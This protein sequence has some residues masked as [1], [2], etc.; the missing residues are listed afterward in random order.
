MTVMTH[1]CMQQWRVR[2]AGIKLNFDK[3][4][5]KS[6]SCT[7]FGNVY[8]TQ[9]MKPDPKKVEAI[10]KM[11]A[12]QTKQELQSFLGMVNYLGQYIKN[13]AE[14]TANLRLLL[15]KDVL[16]QWTESHEASFQKLKDRISSDVCL[17]YFKSSK[18]VILQ[19]DASKLSLG[20]C[21]LQEDNHGKLIPVAYASKSLT[22]IETR[23]ASIEREMLAVVWGWIKFHHYIYDRKF[24]CQSDHKPLEDIHLKYL[25][26]APP[27]L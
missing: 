13:M 22:P 25:S 27:R 18:P 8:T 6:K 20:G 16:F 19:V 12:P 4:V 23:Y 14:L 7:F 21:L 15:R 26:N 5:I 11:E 1:T 3:C 17:M 9:G 2:S 10:K 24:I